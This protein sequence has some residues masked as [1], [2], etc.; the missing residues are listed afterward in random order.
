MWDDL[1][2]NPVLKAIRERR[3]ISAFFPSELEKETLWQMLDAGRWAPS[4]INSQPWRFIVVTDSELKRKIGAIGNRK[5]VFSKPSWMDD[6]AVVIVVTVDPEKDPNHYVEDG[7]IAAQNI[8]LAAHSLGYASFYLGIY[9]TKNETDGKTAEDE[10][11]AL[12]QIPEKIRIIAILPIGV[13]ERIKKSSRQDLTDVVYYEK[14]GTT[15]D[16]S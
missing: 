13:P 10:V 5:T 6:A 16:S 4:W 12:L 11:K 9:E 2:D 15:S 8:A 3:S 1:M 14:F 7:A